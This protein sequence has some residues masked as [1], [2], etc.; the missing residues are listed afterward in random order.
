MT[1]ESFQYLFRTERVLRPR[2]AAFGEYVFFR[3][4]FA[5][6]LHR[7]AVVG[8]IVYTV[9][10]RAAHVLSVDGGL[11]YLNEHR[12]TDADVSSATYAFGGA[13]RWKL[14]PTAELS[15]DARFTGVLP[16]PTIGACTRRW[17][18]RRT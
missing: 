2:T 11:G 15:E 3:D 1:A 7:N 14:S 13:Y 9:V 6:I 8:G 5:G 4:E 12:L 18:S 16:R 17:Q 10:N